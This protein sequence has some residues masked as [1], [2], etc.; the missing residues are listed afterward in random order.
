MDEKNLKFVSLLL[1]S[2]HIRALQWE[3][4]KYQTF[5]FSLILGC[6][7]HDSLICICATSGIVC[8]YCSN[9]QWVGSLM[10]TR[11][12]VLGIYLFFLVGLDIKFYGFLW[13]IK[14][15]ILIS[16]QSRQGVIIIVFQF[17]HVSLIE[18]LQ[19][20]MRTT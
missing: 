10:K 7:S 16:Y 12:I 3:K 14:Y 13:S 17:T 8:G 18:S 15:I 19:Y 11:M 6:D 1:T 20:Y 4:K 2:K 9:H 5:R